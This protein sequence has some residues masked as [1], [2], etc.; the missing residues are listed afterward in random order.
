MNE[1]QT[2]LAIVAM[3]LVSLAF[4][5]LIAIPLSAAGLIYGVF[6]THTRNT[7]I[8]RA[9]KADNPNADFRPWAATYWGCV[10]LATAAVGII[11]WT[12][13]TAVMG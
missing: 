13:W 11:Q 12:A 10:A 6:E 1:Y 9:V 7:A 8:I 4:A 3:V 5:P 2:S